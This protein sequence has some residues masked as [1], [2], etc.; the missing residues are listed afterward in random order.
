MIKS[1]ETLVAN[2]CENFHKSSTSI[3]AAVPTARA[4]DLVDSRIGVRPAPPAGG[5]V[6]DRLADRV[7]QAGGLQR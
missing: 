5:R 2:P 1:Y 6:H 7:L 4:G 3:S